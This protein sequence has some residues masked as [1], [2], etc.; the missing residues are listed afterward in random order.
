MPACVIVCV[1][2]AWAMAKI[3]EFDDVVFGYENV[4]RLDVAMQDALTVR[5]RETI[6]ELRDE[7]DRDRFGKRF[8]ALHHLR[9][10]RT[11]DESI[12]MK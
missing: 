11:I 10:G 5:V 3:R 6:A 4:C 1:V 8:A 9:E 2:T 7:V 12:T